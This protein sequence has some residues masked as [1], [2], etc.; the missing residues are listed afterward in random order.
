[1]YGYRLVVRLLT[2]EIPGLRS[3]LGIPKGRKSYVFITVALVE[4]KRLPAR[5]PY[6]CG[7][8]LY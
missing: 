7:P 8:E 6:E 3:S 5:L 1:L 2:E 4:E